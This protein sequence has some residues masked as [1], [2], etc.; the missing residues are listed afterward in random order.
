MNVATEIAARVGRLLAERGWTLSVAESCTGGLISH[1]ITN[2]PG[3]SE[4]YLGGVVAYANEVKRDVLGVP[5]DLLSTY[6][7]VS[8]EVALAMAEGIRTLLGAD[9]SIAVTGIAGPTGGTH[10]KPV[11]TTFVAVSTPP[12]HEVRGHLWNSDR[13]GNKRYSAQAALSLLEEWLTR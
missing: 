4:F 10:A 5:Q 6:G 9:T 7:A 1:W 2:V 12:G 11:G 8:G 13:L 3:S